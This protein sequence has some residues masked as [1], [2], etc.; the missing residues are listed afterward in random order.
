MS[1]W[2]RH[3]TDKLF[4]FW[5]GPFSQWAM[6]PMKV[7]GVEYNCCEQFMM[8]SKARL[9][10]DSHVL[11]AIM[12]SKDPSHQKQWGR[13]V[14]NFDKA[15]WDNVARDVVFMGNYAKFSQHPDLLK[16]LK[17][18][19]DMTIV[20]ASPHDKIWGIGLHARDPRAKDPSKWL[21]T[22]WLGECIMRV[23]TK[24]KREGKI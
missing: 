4:F 8:A 3:N 21:G 1:Y 12:A 10:K 5:S 14:R 20:E 15:A 17:D 2:N 22:N 11:A 18:T 9:F 24:L 16:Q 7:A 13:K 19:G 23:R 6:R